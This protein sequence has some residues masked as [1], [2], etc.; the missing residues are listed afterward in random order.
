MLAV[1]LADCSFTCAIIFAMIIF[2]AM[3]A[4]IVERLT[5]RPP[6]PDSADHADD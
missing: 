3:V 6:G 2:I 1:D 5:K 4:S